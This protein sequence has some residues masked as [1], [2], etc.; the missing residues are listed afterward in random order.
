MTIACSAIT[1]RTPTTFAPIRRGRPSG[2]VPSRF[3]TRYDRSNPVAIARPVKAV[4]STAIASTPGA[5]NV[6][7]SL[8][9]VG[10]T[11]TSEK[12]TSS[13]TGIPTV[14]SNDSPR[15]S[16]IFTSARSCAKN[17][18]TRRPRSGAGI[19]LRD[20]SRFR[21]RKSAGRIRRAKR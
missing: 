1:T 3:N 6:T 18:F 21:A 5:R 7:G 11:S 9:P 12:N 8:V 19:R 2:V 20:V 17:G 16:V 14:S 10:N 4:D 15:V 13:P